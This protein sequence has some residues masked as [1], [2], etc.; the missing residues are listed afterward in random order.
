MGPIQGCCPDGALSGW[1]H[2]WSPVI[3]R[4]AGI[5]GTGAVPHHL[6]LDQACHFPGSVAVSMLTVIRLVLLWFAADIVD[7]PQE[8]GRADAWFLSGV[9]SRSCWL[10]RRHLS[11]RQGVSWSWIRG[12][13]PDEIDLPRR[14]AGVCVDGRAPDFQGRRCGAPQRRGSPNTCRKPT[15]APSSASLK[16]LTGEQPR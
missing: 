3:S 10:L 5:Q 8:H 15:G 14:F 6:D 11:G 4:T 16:S 2:C 12:R 7:V 1:F 13:T 9:P